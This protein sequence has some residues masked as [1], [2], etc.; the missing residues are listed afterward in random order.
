MTDIKAVEIEGTI[1]RLRTMA[2]GS[3]D[4]TINL[5]EYCG[6]QAGLMIAWI[7]ELV[8]G[9]LEVKK[10]TEIDNETKKGAKGNSAG[11]GRRRLGN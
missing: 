9:V 4:L 2:D 10:L 8:G 3:I 6:A 5:P 11:V 7:N 1:K